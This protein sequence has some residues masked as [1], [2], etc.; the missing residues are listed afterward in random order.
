MSLTFGGSLDAV[1]LH[2]HVRIQVVQGAI[3]F[4]AAIP[5]AFVHSLDFLIAA[6][7]SLVLLCTGDRDEGVHL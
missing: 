6:A 5:A 4:F 1:R 3:G 7:R 2:R